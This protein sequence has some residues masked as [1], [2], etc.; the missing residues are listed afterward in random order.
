MITLVLWEYAW[1]C[2]HNLEGD[3]EPIR[4][5]NTRL[6][7]EI[8]LFIY[9]IWCCVLSFRRYYS[10]RLPIQG[11]KVLITF[12][13][14]KIYSPIICTL[15]TIPLRG[16]HRNKQ[17]F[18]FIQRFQTAL[19]YWWPTLCENHIWVDSLGALLALGLKI[20]SWCFAPTFDL[21]FLDYVRASRRSIFLTLSD[22]KRCLHKVGNVT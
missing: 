9:Y 16:P 14:G 21:L 5:Q 12:M 20:P 8:D 15:L 2:F 18:H 3:Y 4:K 10:W 13:C 6:I 1:Q 17:S 11:M 19:G 7:A 22:E